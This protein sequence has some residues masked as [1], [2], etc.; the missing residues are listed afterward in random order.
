MSVH[1]PSER[2]DWPILKLE[3]ARRI[4]L[5]REEIYGEHGGPLLAESLRIPY[6]TWFNY[7]SGCTVPA[8]TILRFIEL[9][10][11]NPSW[12]LTG[13]GDKYNSRGH[14]CS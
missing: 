13:D 5:I 10:D 3:L 1:E 11:A 12:L 7:E 6:R 9:T 8:Q 4:R 2:S 14:L